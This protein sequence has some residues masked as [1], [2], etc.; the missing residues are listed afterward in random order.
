MVKDRVRS[1]G[2]YVYEGPFKDRSTNVCVCVCVRVGGAVSCLCAFVWYFPRKLIKD[3]STSRWWQ[4]GGSME[5]WWWVGV[6]SGTLRWFLSTAVVSATFPV[7]LRRHECAFLHICCLRGQLVGRFVLESRS[8]WY[9]NYYFFFLF[10][11]LG[12]LCITGIVVLNGFQSGGFCMW[13]MTAKLLNR[14]AT[15][16]LSACHRR[17][18]M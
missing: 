4:R 6:S 10:A 17:L 18:K 11:I 13:S 14:N 3:S 5:G 16:T 15:K 12:G 1:W 2:M 7:S 8:V 9:L